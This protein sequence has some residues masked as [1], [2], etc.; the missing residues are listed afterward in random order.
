MFHSPSR[1]T[2][3]KPGHHLQYKAPADKTKDWYANYSIDIKFGLDHC[4]EQS[5]AFHYIK[6]DLMKRM[7]A[8]LYG[9]CS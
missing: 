7:H 3:K 2:I 9:H 5:V 6:P 4:S 1:K 8:I